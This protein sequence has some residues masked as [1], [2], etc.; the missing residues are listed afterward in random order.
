MATWATV[1]PALLW[2]ALGWALAP[3]GGVPGRRRGVATAAFS[4]TG[5]KDLQ[6]GTFGCVGACTTELKEPTGV[7]ST[8]DYCEDGNWTKNTGT[9]CA[10][11]N[12][13][14]SSNEQGGET[15]GE[16]IS[17]DVGGVEDLAALFRDAAN[18]N[19]PLAAWN[20][21]RAT[22]M[23]DMFRDA[24]N[25]N[26]PLE[27]WDVSKVQTMSGMFRSAASFNA[28][29]NMWDVGAVTDMSE[30]FRGFGVSVFN[31]P[32]NRWDVSRV[33]TMSR[34]F[35]SAAS[36]NAPLNMWDVGA[37]TDMSEMFRGF[38]VS[39]FNSP[40]NRWDVSRVQTMSGMFRS[41]TSFNVPL[42]MWDVSRAETMA[43]M[44]KNAP[45]FNQPLGR[46]NIQSLKDLA[47]PP[48]PAPMAEMFAYSG[49]HR[50][51]ICTPAWAPRKIESE[52]GNTFTGTTSKIL[53]CYRT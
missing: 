23:S 34:M 22:D 24:K 48:T 9:A 31:S 11:A 28:P 45:R 10:N 26:S 43:Q 40:L 27:R 17:W 30:M 14:V 36:F 20:V 2:V 53:C 25:F 19:A 7:G 33:Q 47:K 6:S 15:F 5:R 52:L 1:P 13:P 39:V 37:V 49:M 51:I 18:F 21:Q 44:F 32:L 46:W 38:G 42:N 4:P 50:Q 29:L 12:D 3:S 41:A 35:R 16:I 8:G